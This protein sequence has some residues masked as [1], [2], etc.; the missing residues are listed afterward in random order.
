RPRW[1]RAARTEA[2]ASSPP[3]APN[4]SARGTTIPHSPGSRG[5]FFS[6]EPQLH[7]RPTE[8]HLVAGLQAHAPAV[9]GADVDGLAAPVDARAR[10][11]LLGAQP[12]A[13]GGGVPGDAG[14]LAGDGVV[15]LAFLAEGDVVAPPNPA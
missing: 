8:V 6:T 10:G 4:L 1:H 2:R 14:V 15:D 3:S 5:P 13:A 12:V 7:H 9:V 11:V